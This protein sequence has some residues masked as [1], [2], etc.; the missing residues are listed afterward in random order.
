MKHAPLLPLAAKIIAAI[1]ISSSLLPAQQSQ[2]IDEKELM[3]WADRGDA[4]AQFEIGLR[5]LTG[6]G[7]KKNVEEGIK[8][9]EKAAKQKHLRAQHVMGTIYEDGVGVKQDLAK[10]AEWY[11]TS[12]ELGFALSQHSLASLYEEGKGVKK[13]TAKAAEWFKKAADQG[14]MQSQTAYA[15]KLERGEGVAKSSSKAALW[16]LKAAQQDFV[17]AMTRLANLYYTGQGVPV[18]YRRAGAWYRR[19]AQSED[20][21][22]SNNLAWF[23]ATCPEDSLHNGESAVLLARRALKLLAEVVQSDEQ[24]YAMIDTMAAALARNGE[25]KEAELWQKRCIALFKDDKEKDLPPEERKKLQEEFDARL[26]LYQKS[27]P[28]A[29]PEP[30]GEEGAEPLPQDTILQDEGLPESKPK[31]TTPKS[32]RGTVV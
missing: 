31:K 32:G 13:D 2:R 29:E 24:P 23:L 28:F 14:Y 15:A 6:E 5:K 8:F 4:D 17:P 10:A 21:W 25:F 22:A 16:Y 1:L 11:R 3:T 20:P 19:A 30:K 12:A 27:T 26:K 18:D 7:V 9:V